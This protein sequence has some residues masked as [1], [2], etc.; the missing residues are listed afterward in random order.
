MPEEAP[1]PSELQRQ[2]QFLGGGDGSSSAAACRTR[3]TGPGARGTPARDQG[4]AGPGPVPERAPGRHP[5]GGAGADHRLKEEVEKLTAPPSGFGSFVSI[6]EDGTINITSGGRKLRVNVH[7]DI[8]PQV[9]QHGCE[10]M[11]NDA[12]NVVEA[13]A[14]GSRARP[15]SSPRCSGSTGP[16]HRQ[17]RAGRADRRAAQPHPAGRRL[18]AAGRALRVRARAPAQAGGRGAWPW[19]RC[20]SI[21]YQDIGGL[22]DQIEQIR[23]AVELPFLHA[24]LFAEH[25]LCRPRASCSTGPRA[26]A[27]P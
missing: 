5:A 21:P 20:P 8:D 19:R 11:L 15:C 13:C 26:A 14:F 27:R 1:E 9:A 18:A 6:N 3:P 25:Q 17:R 23:D 16:G 12:L 2:I 10:P 7:P 4:P 24:D 22:A